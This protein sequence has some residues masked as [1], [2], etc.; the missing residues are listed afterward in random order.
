MGIEVRRHLVYKLT[1]LK[2]RKIYIGKYSGKQFDYYYGSGVV[3]A[4]AMKKYGKEN[5]KKEILFE[6]RTEQ[7]A[8]DK[9]T[10]L[11]TKE[12]IKKNKTYNL[13]VGGRSGGV[14]VM[15][16]LW[17][18]K[19]SKLHALEFL[20]RRRKS[21]KA[22]KSTPE[23]RKRQS[24]ITKAAWEDMNSGLNSPERIKKIKAAHQALRADPNS[25]YNTEDFHKKLIAGHQSKEHKIAAS[26]RMK[27]AHADP[28]SKLN[29]TLKSM[30]FRLKLSKIMKHSWIKRRKI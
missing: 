4:K 21:Q 14:R 20:E 1:N 26:E 17:A 16:A 24:E 29:Q 25:V 11:V 23:N 3:I 9:E 15:N 7:E 13:T 27:K 19:S 28:N 6:F 8:W 10:E 18:D 12:F 2:N 5:F 30:E 22:A